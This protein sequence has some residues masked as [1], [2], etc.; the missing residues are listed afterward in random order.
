MHIIFVYRDTQST[1]LIV[2]ERIAA[3]EARLAE[4]G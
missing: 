2:T 1:L 4:E 3:E